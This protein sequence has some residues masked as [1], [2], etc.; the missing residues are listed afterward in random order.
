MAFTVFVRTRDYDI[1][2]GVLLAVTG[3][4]AVFAKL[5]FYVVEVRLLGLMSLLAWAS[6]M[7]LLSGF[8]LCLIL[9]NGW[10]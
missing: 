3:C 8:V 1:L 5:V 4:E 6:S 7:H 9:S 10:H 2:A